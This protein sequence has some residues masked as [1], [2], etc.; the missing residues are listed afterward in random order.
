MDLPASKFDLSP[1]D[2]LHLSYEDLKVVRDTIYLLLH[3]YVKFHWGISRNEEVQSETRSVWS[4]RP[5]PLTSKCNRTQNII[6]STY[7]ASWV[8]YPFTLTN[9]TETQN[10]VCR[11]I[12]VKSLI[13]IYE[14][15]DEKSCTEE[16][17]TVPIDN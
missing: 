10:F 6:W 12:L 9:L 1:H 11:Y 5:W 13:K 7:G 4:V 2:N 15:T 8:N 16:F 17:W 14:G 3:I